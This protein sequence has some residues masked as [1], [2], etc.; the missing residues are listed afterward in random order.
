MLI[1]IVVIA[2][3]VNC[4]LALAQVAEEVV[5]FGIGKAKEIE[6]AP[7][8][9][10]KTVDTRLSKVIET[11]KAAKDIITGDKPELDEKTKEAMKDL[12]LDPI[13]IP[14]NILIIM[15]NAQMKADFLNKEKQRLEAELRATKLQIDMWNVTKMT[16]YWFYLA[17]C[18]VKKK[19]YRRWVITNGVARYRK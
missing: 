18:G 2:L 5:V 11:V 15:S 10:I 17:D 19:D 14:Q 16:E 3:I 8:E 13:P 7:D 4:Q 1:G 6:T 12:K 9:E